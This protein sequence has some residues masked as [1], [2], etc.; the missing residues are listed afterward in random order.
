MNLNEVD[1][2][3]SFYLV[4]FI[5]ALIR[6]VDDEALRLRTPNKGD[7]ST[8]QTD[9]KVCDR[10]VRQIIYPVCWMQPFT[11]FKVA[12]ALIILRRAM[13]SF[14]AEISIIS[15]ESMTLRSGNNNEWEIAARYVTFFSFSLSFRQCEPSAGGRESRTRNPAGTTNF[16]VNPSAI[17]RCRRSGISSARAQW[18]ETGGDGL[19][20]RRRSVVYRDR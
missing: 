20:G 7:D 19:P 17:C 11:K 12:K 9:G 5:C 3:N 16:R 1:S 6:T 10:S 2:C 8:L 14:L 4:V 18:A 13:V 15:L